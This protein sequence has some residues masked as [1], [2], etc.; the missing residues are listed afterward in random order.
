MRALPGRAD[1]LAEAR[2]AA[3]QLEIST[4]NQKIK[5]LRVAVSTETDAL[6]KC[7]LGVSRAV[8]LTGLINYTILGVDSILY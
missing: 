3:V 2:P 8:V 5:V 6:V 7:S 1:S 4:K